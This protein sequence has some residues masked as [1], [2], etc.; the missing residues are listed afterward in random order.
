MLAYV[1]VFYPWNSVAL[2]IRVLYIRYAYKTEILL[3]ILLLEYICP[4]KPDYKSLEEM[5]WWLMLLKQTKKTSLFLGVSVKVSLEDIIIVVQAWVG[6][7]FPDMRQNE[8]RIKFIRVGR[9]ESL[10]A[11]QAGFLTVRESRQWTGVLDSFLYPGVRSGKGVLWV[12]CWINEVG[13]LGGGWRVRQIPS[14]YMRK[15]WGRLYWSEGPK[16]H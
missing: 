10:P 16:I 7:E 11:Q 15:G 6:K 14:P 5:L 8:R 1:I 12:I 13:M 2:I 3:V 9:G 4:L